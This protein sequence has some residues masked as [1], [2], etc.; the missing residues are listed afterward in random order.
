ML[1]NRITE[2]QEYE[3]ALS[4]ATQLDGVPIT[5]ALHILTELAP[6]LITNTHAINNE[7]INA[8]KERLFSGGIV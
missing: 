7:L 2:E 1:P 4:F 6:S 3:K 8:A 5:Q